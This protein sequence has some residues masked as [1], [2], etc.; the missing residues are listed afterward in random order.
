MDVLDAR[1]GA[2]AAG[3]WK[4]MGSVAG[5]EHPPNLKALGDLSGSRPKRNIDQFHRQVG[6]TYAARASSRHRCGVKSSGRS[7]LAGWKARR[8]NHRSVPC[9]QSRVP[10]PIAEM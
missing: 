10:F 9:A 7:P 8:I 6:D 3:W 5:Q 1:V 2:K 4:A